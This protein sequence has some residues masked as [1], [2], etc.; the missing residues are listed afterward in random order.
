[1]RSNSSPEGR[2]TRKGEEK[3]ETIKARATISVRSGL[4]SPLPRRPPVNVASSV[5]KNSRIS[6]TDQVHPPHDR[7]SRPYERGR[8]R[9]LFVP[10]AWT[11][12]ARFR[13]RGRFVRNRY[14]ANLP[15]AGSLGPP[16]AA[17]YAGSFFLRA[18][19]PGHGEPPDPSEASPR[20]WED[21]GEPVSIDV[22]TPV[23]VGCL[24]L[25]LHL[26]KQRA[27]QSGSSGIRETSFLHAA[28][29]VGIWMRDA[30]RHA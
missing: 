17:G 22:A 3:K 4:F 5:L 21:K 7:T 25:A 19:F 18:R 28:A 27:A 16:S 9:R 10:L 14:A 15:P 20:G 29:P 11:T 1:V 13:A 30:Y 6:L 26:A 8:S 23:A 12:P 24:L 2:L